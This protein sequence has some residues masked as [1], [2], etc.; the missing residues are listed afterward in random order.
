VDRET[1]PESAAVHR[2]ADYPMTGDLSREHWTVPV[3]GLT[4]ADPDGIVQAIARR[5]GTVSLHMTCGDTQTTGWLDV[6][7]AAQLCTGIWE[8]A[9]ASQQLTGHLRDDQ[10]LPP[11]HGSGI[12][13]VAG[14]APRPRYPTPT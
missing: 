3:H 4:R 12:R 2:I 10:P 11:P 8:T 7:R 6:S 14:R 5:D 13:P 9:G 1:L